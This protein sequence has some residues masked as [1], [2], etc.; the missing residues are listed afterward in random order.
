VVRIRPQDIVEAAMAMF[1]HA[2]ADRVDI[3]RR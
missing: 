1:E 2:V 3:H